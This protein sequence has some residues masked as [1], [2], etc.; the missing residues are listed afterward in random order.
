MEILMWYIL[1][2]VTTSLTAIYE[3]FVPVMR[4]LQKDHPDN[5]VIEYKYITYLVFFS[6]GMLTAPLLIISCIL[7]EYSNRFREALLK[8]LSKSTT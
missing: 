4:I 8:S 2:C 7:P 3:L 6:I 1:F 5:P